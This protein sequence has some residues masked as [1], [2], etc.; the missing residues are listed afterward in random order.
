MRYLVLLLLVACGT[1][2]P[3]ATP[4][5]EARAQAMWPSATVDELNQGR[6]VLLG[7]CGACHRPPS[8]SDHPPG[9]WPGHIAEMAPRA[10][11][12]SEDRTLLEHYVVTMASR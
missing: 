11:L 1:N 10:H 5:D 8:P 7:H 2:A 3:L 9:E 12:S 4:A 6:K